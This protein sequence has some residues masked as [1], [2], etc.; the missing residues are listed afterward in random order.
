MLAD[1]LGLARRR[2]AQVVTAALAV[3][4]HLA[5]CLPAMAAV[6]AGVGKTRH[7]QL[8][9]AVVVAVIPQAH[10]RAVR[11]EALAVNQRR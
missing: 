7:L 4:Q 5:H 10:P 11:L 3:T 2:V 6:V 8:A 1:R 9:A